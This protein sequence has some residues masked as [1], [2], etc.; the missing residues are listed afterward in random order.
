MR[1]DGSTYT[2]AC[3]DSSWKDPNCFQS[4]PKCTPPHT[5]PPP[6]IQHTLL[7]LTLTAYKSQGPNTLYRCSNEKWCCSKG[8]NIT[9]CCSDPSVST[10]NGTEVAGDIY[11]GSAWAPGFTLVQFADPKTGKTG[12][13]FPTGSAL[14]GKNGTH[15][16]AASSCPAPKNDDATKVGLGVGLGVGVPLLAALGAVLFLWSKERRSNRDLRQGVG[17]GVGKVEGPGYGYAGNGNGGQKHW[18]EMPDEETAKELP[19]SATA[20]RGEL[21]GEGVQR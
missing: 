16:A 2:G 21:F 10:F 6:P 9:S 12:G 5:A 1:Y 7:T 19:T 15:S 17:Q 4:C 18:H 11:N 3:T 20:G 8:G 13:S 14:P